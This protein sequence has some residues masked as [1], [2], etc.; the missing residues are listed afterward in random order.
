VEGHVQ[1]GRGVVVSKR[2]SALVGKRKKAAPG[3]DGPRG[4]VAS[5]RSRRSRA[6]ITERKGPR[7]TGD[8]LVC[9]GGQEM[10]FFPSVVRGRKRIGNVRARV[11]IRG[12][13]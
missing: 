8:D 2:L 11:V 7:G 10:G 5:E 13:L 6:A 3:G 4:A 9:G 1:K 12:G